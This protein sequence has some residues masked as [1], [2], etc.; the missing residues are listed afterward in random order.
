MF[1]GEE[2]IPEVRSG[3]TVE[4]AGEMAGSNTLLIL[5]GSM[6]AFWLIYKFIIK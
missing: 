6:V 1:A 5:G 4:E 3:L 2:N